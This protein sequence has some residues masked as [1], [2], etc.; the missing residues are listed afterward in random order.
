[1]YLPVPTYPHTLVLSSNRP[2]LH[3]PAAVPGL[4]NWNDLDMF[5]CGSATGV[6]PDWMCAHS[7][8]PHPR[9]GRADSASVKIDGEREIAESWR[10]EWLRAAGM[11]IASLTANLQFDSF[12]IKS[13]NCCISDWAIIQSRLNE[14]VHATFPPY[15]ARHEGCSPRE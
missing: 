5:P 15:Y 14:T 3:A 8:H 10:M 1:M 12:S 9:P 6:L 4:R 11:T 2:L 7:G 13:I